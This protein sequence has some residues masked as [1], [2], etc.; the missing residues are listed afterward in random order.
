[1]V[2]KESKNLEF[3]ERFSQTF[4]KTVSAFANGE[5]VKSFLVWPMLDM[6]WAL[7]T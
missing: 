1:M 2:F 6:W 4:L 7:T 5:G 3:K